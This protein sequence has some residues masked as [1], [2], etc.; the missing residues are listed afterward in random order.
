M[1]DIDY[2]V[3]L[4]DL[5]K[6]LVSHPED[7]VVE[8]AEQSDNFIRLNVKVNDLDTGR[9]IG[10]K[11]RIANAIRTIVHAA[12]VRCNMRVDVDMGKAEEQEE[13]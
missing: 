6:P 5:V 7:V 4:A 11:G 13:E 1:G 8:I 3:L 12:A 9:I 10:K 2:Q